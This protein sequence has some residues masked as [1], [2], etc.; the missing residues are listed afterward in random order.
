MVKSLLQVYTYT[1]SKEK[2]VVLVEGK[3]VLIQLVF[4]R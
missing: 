2:L 4:Y 1:R 3:S